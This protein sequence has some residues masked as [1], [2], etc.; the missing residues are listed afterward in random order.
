M[1][2]LNSFIKPILP[3][4]NFNKII[5]KFFLLMSFILLFFPW[6]SFTVGTGQITAINPNERI[7][8]IT[9]PVGGFIKAW[10]INE[11]DRVKEGQLI[12]DLVDNDPDLLGRLE[13][14]KNAAEA[15]L[16]S[17]KLMMETALIDLERQKKLFSQGLSSRKDYEKSK[18]EYSKISVEYSK[19]LSTFTKAQTQLSRQSTQ[20]ILAPRNGIITRI[21]PTER[22]MLIKASAPLAIFAPDVKTPAAEVWIDGN[23]ASILTVGQ[24]ARLQF[25]GW[26]AIQIPGWPSIAIGTFEGKVHLIDQASSQGGKF[27]VLITATSKWPTQKI[28]RLGVHA[29]AYIKLNDSFILKE[30]WRQLNGFPARLAPIEDELNKMLRPKEEKDKEESK[31]KK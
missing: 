16:N 11:G 26:P 13:I 4:M 14:E 18:I 19:N 20:R 29:K 15:G 28:L 9:A 8:T 27:R 12:A 6:I 21:L 3:L 24:T 7:Q 5:L 17:A 25:E 10:H 22:G 1:D 31:D 2:K 23:D 30:I